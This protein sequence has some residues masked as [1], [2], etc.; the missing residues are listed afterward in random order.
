MPSIKQYEGLIKML[1]VYKQSA[2]VRKNVWERF[3][4]SDQERI[5]KEIFGTN[6]EVEISR[7]EVLNEKD[8]K[9]KIVM[10][11]MWGYPTGGRGL[12]IEN[13]LDNLEEIKE[14]LSRVSNKNLK[15]AE[16]DNL[17]E[18]FSNTRGLGISTWSKLLYFFDVEIDSMKCQIYD[19]KIKESLNKQQFS[20]LGSRIWKQD[21]EHYYRYIELVNELAKRMCVLPDQV[22]LFLFSFN[23]SYK[24]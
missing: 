19:S 8:P 10:T 14:W 22:E 1:P 20:E 17:I 12:N 21:V 13:T 23:Y 16:A 5:E 15:K 11:L 2:R 24:F 18:N 7:E 4:Y 9:K 3:S 6:A